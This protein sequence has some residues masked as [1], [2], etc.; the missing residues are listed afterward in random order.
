MILLLLLQAKLHKIRV[1]W[2]TLTKAATT[3]LAQHDNATLE[4]VP[5]TGLLS[6]KWET[7]G[8]YTDISDSSED[9]W[10]SEEGEEEEVAAV[11]SAKEVRL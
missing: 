3:L 8:E 1:R 6:V 5:L 4:E 2:A 9:E 11:G 7:K 10:D